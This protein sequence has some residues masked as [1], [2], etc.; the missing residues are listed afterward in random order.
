MKTI[1]SLPRTE[2]RACFRG[3][4][5]KRLLTAGVLL[6]SFLLVGCSQKTECVKWDA[7]PYYDSTAALFR[8]MYG[9][10]GGSEDDVETAYGNRKDPEY[11]DTYTVAVFGKEETATV[12]YVSSGPGN[13]TKQVR[14]FKIFLHGSDAYYIDYG[15]ALKA[16]FGDPVSSDQTPYEGDHGVTVWNSYDAGNGGEVRFCRDKDSS[17]IIVQKA[18]QADA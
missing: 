10:I 12:D 9:L 1:F 8:E 15:E 6:F 4:Q 2:K 18:E 3:K 17:W 11:T 7:A 5:Q 13:R 16:V 14:D